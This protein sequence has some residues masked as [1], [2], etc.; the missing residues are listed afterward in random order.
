[1]IEEH[2]NTLYFD[3][4]IDAIAKHW[5]RHNKGL[6]VWGGLR[7]RAQRVAV[8]KGVIVHEARP[9]YGVL[10]GTGR[11]RQHFI[12][13]LQDRLQNLVIVETRS[14]ASEEVVT[15]EGEFFGAIRALRNC[16]H[17]IVHTP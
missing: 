4:A 17:E 12:D 5:Q 13:E 8:L 2:V 10:G 3:K 6:E 16:Y 15:A 11:T 14:S 1:M 7:S 9:L